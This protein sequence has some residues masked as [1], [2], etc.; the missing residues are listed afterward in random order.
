MDF[1]SNLANGFM[2]LFQ[3]GGETF[4]GWVTGIIPMIVC[5]M[6][7]VN[8]IIKII[9][10]ERVERVTKLATKF[11][12]TRYTIVPIMAVL[13]LGNPMCYTFGRFVEEKHK[14]A[15]YDSCVSFLHPVTGLFPHANP[16]ELFVYMGIAAGVQQL[17]LP[18]GNLGVRYFI[19]GIIVI[20]IRGILTEK[21]Y[22]RMISKGDTK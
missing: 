6:T 3:A 7:A 1:I 10:E 22:M 5:L 2:S 15:Y 8:S 17:G 16:G 21:I 20:L 13:F 14:P 4:M 18:I 9:G 12:I 11:I 19:V